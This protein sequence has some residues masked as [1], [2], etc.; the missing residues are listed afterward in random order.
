MTTAYRQ[1]E[2]ELEARLG[3][4]A[5]APGAKLPTERE[6]AVQMG[7]SRMTVRQA[8]GRL[9]ERGLL[10]RQQGRGTFAAAPKLTQSL[11]I[12]S[13]FFEEMVHQGVVPTSRVLERARMPAT[14]ALARTLGVAVGEPLYKV[15]RL[16]LG[17]GEPLV[18]ATSY[19]P[20]RRVP[21]LLERDLEHS[22]IYRL[23]DEYSARPVRAIQTLE[24]T[25]ARGDAAEALGVPSGSPAMLVERTAWDAEGQPVEY[26]RDLYRGD[27]HRFVAELRLRG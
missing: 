13:G 22:S 11:S 6:L 20:A 26:A 25:I 1:I 3:A 5:W 17:S 23:M 18:L 14:Q 9:A 16:R 12:L 15:V 2:E 27:R 24:P 7:V 21:G 19:L 10:L 4:G 8:L